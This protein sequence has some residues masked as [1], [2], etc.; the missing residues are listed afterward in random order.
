[1]IKLAAKI[2]LAL[3]ICCALKPAW[4][5][6]FLNSKSPSYEVDTLY[7]DDVFITGAR[8]KF[9][10]R[11]YGDLFSFSYEIVQTDSVTGNFM[12]LGYSVQNLAPVVGSFRGM[13]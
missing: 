4:G 2:V 7:E 11:V 8:I 10:S 5:T 13:A 12:A 1:M 6:T 3:A 9:D